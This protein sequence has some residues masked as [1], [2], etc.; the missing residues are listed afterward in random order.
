MMPHFK[1]HGQIKH[2]VHSYL[3]SPARQC[4]RFSIGYRAT[5]VLVAVGVGGL[6]LLVAEFAGRGALHAEEKAFLERYE[7]IRSKLAHDDLA[8]AQAESSVLARSMR[9]RSGRAARV[10]V[11]SKTLETARLGFAVLSRQAVSMARNREGYY[12]MYCLPVGCPQNC[13]NCPM[14]RFSDWVQT[15]PAVENPFVGVGQ[16]G[17]GLVRE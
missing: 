3:H 15:N 5:A 1:M 10:I 6:V 17:C 9:T 8:G 11:E 13:E 14:S 4:H 2:V 12:V 16:T 7:I